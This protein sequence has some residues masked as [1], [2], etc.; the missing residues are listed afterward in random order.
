VTQAVDFDHEDRARRPTLVRL[1]CV[2]L[3]HSVDEGETFVSPDID[4]SSTAANLGS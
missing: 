1:A 4:D 3:R 2:L